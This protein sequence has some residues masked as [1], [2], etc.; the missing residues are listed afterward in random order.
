MITIS[1]TGHRPSKLN[2]CYN[3]DNPIIPLI[4]KALEEHILDIIGTYTEITFITGAALGVDQIAF[5]TVHK[6]K[7]KYPHLKIRNV[8]AV[9]YK[10]QPKAWPSYSQEWYG[11]MLNLAD[12]IIY[13]DTISAYKF[14]L[15]EGTHSNVKLQKRNEYMVDHSDFVIAVWNF[16]PGGTGNCVNY[17]TTKGKRI[18]I[19]NSDPI[20]L[21]VLKK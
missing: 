8:I 9:P 3:W 19:I 15:P 18:R 5:W 12:D 21:E 6:M 20:L 11:K 16:T 13:V 14:G 1:F 2:N 4:S 17:A 7:K 10:D